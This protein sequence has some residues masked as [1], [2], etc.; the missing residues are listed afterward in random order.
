MKIININ[1][2]VSEKVEMEDTREASVQVPISSKDGTPTVSA[3]VFTLEPNGHTPFHTHDWEHVNYVIS[4]SGI[5][6]DNDGKE[7]W[8]EKGDFILVQPGEMHQYRNEIIGEPL[9]F[10]CIVPKE[11]ECWCG[12]DKD[13]VSKIR[14]TP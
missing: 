5:V 4:G 12:K 14:R 13:E 10:I 2:S 7:Y 3:R 8:I 1:D 6:I 9:V 11:H